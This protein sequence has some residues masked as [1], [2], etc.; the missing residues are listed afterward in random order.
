MTDLQLSL[1]DLKYQWNDGWAQIPDSI[2]WA[3]HDIV[4]TK[5]GRIITGHPDS[6]DILFFDTQ[7]V[8]LNSW[9]A[10]VVETHG[11]CL[12]VENGQEIFWLADIG[13]K[14][15]PSH[16]YEY[17]ANEDGKVLKCSLDGKVLAEIEKS[18]IPGY[19]ADTHF[20]PTQVAVHQETG[21]IWITDGYGQSK[22]HRLSKSFDHLK[23][24]DGTEG[25][26]RFDGP[27]G[28]FIDTRKPDPEL[29][30]A[31]RESQRVQIYDLEGTFK[32]CIGENILNSPSVF[33]VDGDNMIVGELFA[34]I[35]VL[36]RD[37]Q[38]IGFLGDGSEYVE[39]PGW[40]NRSDSDEN[41]VRPDDLVRGKFNSPHGMAVDADGSIYVSEWFIGG[42]YTKLQR[43]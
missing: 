16:N 39:K 19:E 13:R 14:R 24:V 3:H 30:I 31:D 11:F 6:T 43:I 35:A 17:P 2:G 29:Y 20:S 23:T 8:L 37:D 26:G 12:S 33:D 42:R 40:P 32:R 9:T 7:G 27:H 22:T 28:V 15:V 38:L 1:G 34:R 41:P 5:D 18:A 4:V 10:P 36:D 25:V 21:D